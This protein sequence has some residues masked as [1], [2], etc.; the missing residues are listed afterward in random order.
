MTK[1]ETT[2]SNLMEHFGIRA[3]KIPE[4]NEKSPDFEL[5]IEGQS[6]YWE[7]K[8]L[9]E[10]PEE[11]K[12]MS[13]I[14]NDSNDIYSVNSKRVERIIS[15]AAKQ[16]TGYGVTE[17]PCVVA[18]M[19]NRDFA[20]KDFFL[21]QWVRTSMLGRAEILL[22]DEVSKELSREPG[23]LTNRKKYISAV[24]LFNT[25]NTNIWCFHNPNTENSIMESS[26]TGIFKRQE[27][28]VQKE[29]GLYWETI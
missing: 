21:P 22:T 28:A 24:V 20:V 12:I 6:Q 23:L 15:D 16:F 8:E 11:L 29:N 2:F 14:N 26:L 5:V 25:R 27:V 13:D 19:D 17:Y 10:N 1:S 9:E 7:I 18:L 3:E 4:G